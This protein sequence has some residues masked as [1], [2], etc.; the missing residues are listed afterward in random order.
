[1]SEFV[2]QTLDLLG[3]L[4]LPAIELGD[5]GDQ[6]VVCGGGVCGALSLG[7]LNDC[8]PRLEPSY[9]YV[10][11]GTSKAISGSLVIEVA[12]PSVYRFDLSFKIGDGLSEAPLACPGIAS[13]LG[14]ALAQHANRDRH[15][16]GA[17]L[18]TIA[19]ELRAQG[20]SE[21]GRRGTHA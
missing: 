11:G 20:T 15:P 12:Q 19:L 18:E 10:S 2:R 3:R 17:M 13:I 1:M 4:Q 5:L 21:G 6:H 9:S 16:C 8:H 14:C 7:W